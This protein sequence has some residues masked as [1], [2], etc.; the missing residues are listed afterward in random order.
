M[1]KRIFVLGAI[2]GVGIG[3]IFIFAEFA[4]FLG[5]IFEWD[6]KDKMICF[7]IFMFTAYPLSVAGAIVGAQWAAGVSISDKDGDK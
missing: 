7:G 3:G 1:K 6:Q 2:A 5:G 4:Q